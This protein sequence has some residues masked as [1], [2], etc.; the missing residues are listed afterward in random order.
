[1]CQL[2]RT[3]PTTPLHAIVSKRKSSDT[4]PLPARTLAPDDMDLRTVLECF[5]AAAF[6]PLLEAATN[7]MV[8][9][10]CIQVYVKERRTN[11]R[12]AADD[13][14]ARKA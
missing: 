5:A 9:A 2:L 14:A 7:A 10:V 8:V 11:E 1:M 6:A 3:L 13:S 12:T 4:Y